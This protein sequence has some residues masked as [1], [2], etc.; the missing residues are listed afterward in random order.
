M[1]TSKR[2]KKFIYEELKV[3]R[4]GQGWGDE[5]YLN[6]NVIIYKFDIRGINGFLG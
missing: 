3:G 2:R 6:L 5:E 4:L 1:R